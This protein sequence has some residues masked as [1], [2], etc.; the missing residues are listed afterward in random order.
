[1]W[2]DGQMVIINISN[3]RCLNVRWWSLF[4]GNESKQP[5]TS[6]DV[7]SSILWNKKSAGFKC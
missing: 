4:S 1:M 6:K 5:D 2:D 3:I 7:N